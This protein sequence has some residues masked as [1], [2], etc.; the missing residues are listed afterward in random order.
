MQHAETGMLHAKAVISVMQ[1]ILQ[2]SNEEVAKYKVCKAET[3][4][5]ITNNARENKQGRR[6]KGQHT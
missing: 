1:S 5:S 3:L 6:N 2:H 4:G